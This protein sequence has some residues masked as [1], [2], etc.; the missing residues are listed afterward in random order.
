[1]VGHRMRWAVSAAASVAVL[2]L[3]AAAPA[4]AHGSPKAK[5]VRSSGALTDLSV[6]TADATDG[7]RASAFA[8]TRHGHHTRVVLRLRGLDRAS[9]GTTYGAHVHVG[10]CVAGD[11]A[12]AGP[13]YNST[14]GTTVDPTTEVW[15]DVTV[16]ANGT[17]RSSATVPFVIPHGGAKSIVIHAMPTMPNGSAGARLACLPMEF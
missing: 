3:L 8:V 12:A 1:M 2:S 10:S 16:R 14:G 17:A 5:A 6:A 9:A 7:A 4:G 11:G 15:L 13:H